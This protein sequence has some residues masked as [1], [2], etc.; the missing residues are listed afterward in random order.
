V[1]GPGLIKSKPVELMTTIAAFFLTGP[2][3]QLAKV[4]WRKLIIFINVC[5]FIIESSFFVA[6]CKLFDPTI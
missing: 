6:V 3:R 5:S 2:Y 4:L 1:T